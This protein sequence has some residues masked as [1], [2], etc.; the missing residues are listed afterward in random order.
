M[1]NEPDLLVLDEPTEGLDEDGRKLLRSVVKR[2]RQEGKT[3]LIVSHILS[4]VERLCDRVGVIKQGRLLT[5]ASMADL[6]KDPQTGRHR[7][8]SAALDALYEDQD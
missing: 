3:T 6:T 5:V 4:D 7:S 8:L 1:I 2:Q